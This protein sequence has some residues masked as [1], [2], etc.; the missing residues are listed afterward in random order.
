MGEVASRDTI[1]VQARLLHHALVKIHLA[2]NTIPF[3]LHVLFVK[4]ALVDV[5]PYVY[6]GCY[7]DN[8]NS[9]KK[10]TDLEYRDLK[11]RY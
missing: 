6:L 10:G 9:H 8:A 4:M 3:V 1:V 11:V 5:A 7:V 2:Y